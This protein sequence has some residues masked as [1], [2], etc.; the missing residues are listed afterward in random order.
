MQNNPSSTGQSTDGD[1]VQALPRVSEALGR[2][3]GL[4]ERC[5]IVCAEWGIGQADPLE[6]SLKTW[7]PLL[8]VIVVMVGRPQATTL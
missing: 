2:R 5:R 4:A 7:P 6:L 8:T 1:C 3:V